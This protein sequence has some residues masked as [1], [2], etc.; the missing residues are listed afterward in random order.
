[1]SASFATPWT[2]AFQVTLCMWFPRLGMEWVAIFFS[3]GSSRPRDWA[4]SPALADWFLMPE[5]PGKH[6]C[7]HLVQFSC[8]VKSDP[9]WP[10]DCC[11][12]GFPIH[13]QH[14]ELAQTHV[15]RVGV[16]IQP[17]HLLSSTSPSAFNLSQH[18]DLFKWLSSSHQVAKVLEPQLQHQSF[19]WIL[20]NDFL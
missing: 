10:P 6:F 7:F 8:S 14:P 3:R 20:R 5:P 2:V 17:S 1:M 16:A 19:Q 11:P 9:L 18:Q 12:P 4:V 13:H 15:H